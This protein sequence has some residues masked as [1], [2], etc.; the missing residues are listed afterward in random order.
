MARFEIID[1]GT[2]LHCL[3]CGR[4]SYHPAD[5]AQRYC[6][7]CHRFLD[8]PVEAAPDGKETRMTH[9]TLPIWLVLV[10]SVLVLVGVGWFMLR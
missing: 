10:G 4:V 2:G 1:H 8:P 9:I 6:G 7:A 3:W 5:V